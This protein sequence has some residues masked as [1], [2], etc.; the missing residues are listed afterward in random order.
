M[1]VRSTK[2]FILEA[3]RKLYF[4]N[5][6]LARDRT[7]FIYKHRNLFRSVG[8]NLFFQPRLFPDQPSLISIGNNVRISSGVQFI[9]HDIISL[10]LNTKEKTHKYPDYFAPIKIGDNVMIGANTLILPGVK[11]H[12]DVIIAAGSIVTKNI[13]S[14]GVWGGCLVNY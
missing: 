10:M 12:D 3:I 4:K 2:Q 8:E 13:T 7:K 1:K 11:I 5:L 9:N 14:S 6:P